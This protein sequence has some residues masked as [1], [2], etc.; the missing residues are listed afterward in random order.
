MALHS[1][2]STFRI[3]LI[4]GLKSIL[5]E[6]YSIL[7][8]MS[9]TSG[10]STR[11]QT[12]L[13]IIEEDKS[14]S[15]ESGR[16]CCY[17][18][19]ILCIIETKNTD[20]NV[21]DGIPQFW[22]YYKKK[23]NP[24]CVYYISTNYS[25]IIT[26]NPQDFLNQERKDFGSVSV[27]TAKDVG[28]YI[29]KIILEV[30]PLKELE[31]KEIKE[32]LDFNADDI[33]RY[34]SK[35]DSDKL[36]TILDF[37]IFGFKT[38]DDE[39]DASKKLLLVDEISENDFERYKYRVGTYVLI[40]Q[41]MF[42]H[43]FRDSDK[44]TDNDY[45]LPSLSDC[46]EIDEI[47]NCFQLILAI[48]Y[49]PIYKL[50]II[51]LLSDDA[52]DSINFLVEL[53]SIINYKIIIKY[54]L[55]GNLYHSLIP[56]GLRKTLAA[57]YT[58]YEI[59]KFLVE[60]V[61]NNEPG[62]IMDPTCG[63]G[64]FLISAYQKLSELLP[65]K[66]HSEILEII[67]GN[68]ITSFAVLLATVNLALQNVI[69]STHHCQISREDFFDLQNRAYS[70]DD[71]LKTKDVDFISVKETEKVSGYKLSKVK[72]VIGN[73]PFTRGER[74]PSAYSE[75]LRGHFETVGK[76]KFLYKNMP[77]HGYILLD[78]DRYLI[79]N[80]IF[81]F[82]LPLSTL[83][84]DKLEKI[85]NFLIS[86][87]IID[88]IITSE[89][90][91]FSENTGLKE[92]L[93][94]AKRRPN[95]SKKKKTYKTPKEYE[96]DFISL[97]TQ[98]TIRNFK[99]MSKLIKKTNDQT[100]KNLYRLRKVNSLDLFNSFSDDWTFFFESEE[101]LELYDILKE[102]PR[103][104][105]VWEIEDETIKA[106]RGYRQDVSAHWM[107][108]NSEWNVNTEKDT[109]ILSNKTN[110]KSKIKFSD[111]FYTLS[112]QSSQNYNY[113]IID[114]DYGYIIKNN[115]LGGIVDKSLKKYI[116]YVKARVDEKHFNQFKQ[117]LIK[118]GKKF[119]YSARIAFAHRFDLTTGSILCY[120]TEKTVSLNQNWFSIS[121]LQEKDEKLY[122]A[123]FNSS[124]FLLSYIISR[125]QQR[126]PFGQ[127]AVGQ[128]RK[129]LVPT[130]GLFTDKEVDD[131]FNAF[132]DFCKSKLIDVAISDQI[133]LTI[134]N[135][136]E[137]Y[138]LD[139]KILE[140][141]DKKRKDKGK[142]LKKLY[143]LIDN[144]IELMKSQVST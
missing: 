13:I 33:S 2:E 133:K 80:G 50:D 64:T 40:T 141:I 67:Y 103:I 138:K 41:I 116:K 136:N 130:P 120:F 126:G 143:K 57:Y 129:F 106:F 71:Y 85:R 22:K 58:K 3:P 49:E 23:S 110:P 16:I 82:V 94:I 102:N 122:V 55:I 127:T 89:V 115:G 68:D 113:P 87:Y 31:S 137:R 109:L 98:I 35:V 45:D 93:I 17:E 18:S 44:K 69:K 26:I 20:K 34:L 5:G 86:N 74:L 132:S 142:I 134:T 25:S 53:L 4:E 46:E 76:K 48:N 54:D 83:Y 121:G 36:S 128:L 90:E 92:I 84:I 75:K 119:N 7:N 37:Y 39:K 32:I 29:G 77:L 43:I 60:L 72:Y 140:I 12:D 88:Y 56:K 111:D 144:E 114:K 73:P 118:I 21:L 117:Q 28:K 107:V 59:A 70:I 8:E 79:K 95:K 19:D 100:E 105:N 24:R 97:K 66:S 139:L 30:K 15:D 52:F 63:S 96:I 104:N 6:K 62:K 65:T 112:I 135:K 124:L 99:T 131:I 27:Q 78:L 1:T 108:P 61:F 11:K 101:K 42:Y 91:P 14:F 9:G 51:G 10:V 123:W 125:R 81:G 38:A 47:H